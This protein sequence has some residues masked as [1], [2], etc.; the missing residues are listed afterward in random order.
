MKRLRWKG[1]PMLARRLNELIS[2]SDE[3]F[4]GLQF[5]AALAG[6]CRG[7]FVLLVS[8][9]HHDYK[10]T[11]KIDLLVDLCNQANEPWP[12]FQH[13]TVDFTSI[14]DLTV[15]HVIL[16]H[17]WKWNRLLTWFTMWL[18]ERLKEHVLPLNCAETVMQSTVT[19]NNYSV[20]RTGVSRIVRYSTTNLILILRL[21]NLRGNKDL[22][23]IVSKIFSCPI[24]GPQS[25]W[26]LQ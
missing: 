11:F 14:M 2:W 17:Q 18:Q 23:Y 16:S 10:T 1:Y 8:I 22:A 5:A 12:E 9:A 15:L 20:N 26:W 19:S 25:G 3:K 13:F 4:L 6:I 24:M 21:W 7:Y